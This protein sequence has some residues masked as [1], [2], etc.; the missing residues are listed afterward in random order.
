[1]NTYKLSALLVIVVAAHTLCASQVGLIGAMDDYVVDSSVK[2][3]DRAV[4]LPVNPVDNDGYIEKLS[5]GTGIINLMFVC[6]NEPPAE[7]IWD[8]K[9]LINNNNVRWRLEGGVAYSDVVS[10]HAGIRGAYLFDGSSGYM[11]IGGISIRTDSDS[12][13]E[14]LSSLAIDLASATFE[15]WVRL[16]PADLN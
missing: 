4:T 6:G 5:D 10:A 8:N 7:M 11:R 15:M 3:G 2:A 12:Y 16:H 9:G 1:M 13:S 14:I